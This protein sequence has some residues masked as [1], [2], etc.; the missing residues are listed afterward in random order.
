M[1][2]SST[3]R[4]VGCLA[5]TALLLLAG[6]AP[7][8]AAQ[9]GTYLEMESD[10]DGQPRVIK[11]SLGSDR[12]RMD[13]GEEMSVVSIGGDGGKMLLIQH[14]ERSYLEFSTEMMEMMAGILGQMPA[15]MEEKMAE[16]MTPPTFTRTGNTKQVGQWNAYEV[17]VQHPEQDG[18]L[19]MWFSQ[20]VDADFRALVGQV[21]D[22]MSSLRNSPMLD[23]MMGGG[24]GA[25]GMIGQIE[26]QLTAVNMPDGFP[27]QIISSAGGMP[28]TSTLRAIDQ[29]PDFGPETWEA[30]EGY[31]KMAIPFRRD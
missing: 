16:D 2:T 7:G 26:A 18:E 4:M 10:S 21:M 11:L 25:A 17:L 15:Q 13:I 14:A 6:S 30:P 23:G 20:E 27:V 19:T 24:G 1:T 12:L 29:S 31:S 3:T 9:A 22:S 28:S 8:L 5:A